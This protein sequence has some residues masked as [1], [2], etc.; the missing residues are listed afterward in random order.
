ML[1]PIVGTLASIAVI[2]WM[3]PRD[4]GPERLERPDPD[5]MLV[6]SRASRCERL[7]RLHR[8]PRCRAGT[9]CRARLTVGLLSVLVGG[10]GRVLRDRF[11]VGDERAALQLPEPVDPVPEPPSYVRRRGHGH[12]GGRRD[13]LRARR[14]RVVRR[15]ERRLLPDRHGA[16]RATGP[17]GHLAAPDP[18]HGRQ[19][20]GADVRRPARTRSDRAVHHPLVRLE[21]GR[22]RSRRATRSSRASA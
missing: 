12:R 2:W 16:R 14:G 3:S 8:R 4:V 6:S 5:E 15:P 1:P 10:L 9:S 17:E 7:H 19:R 18:R 20:D 22:W 11:E 21:R 13:G